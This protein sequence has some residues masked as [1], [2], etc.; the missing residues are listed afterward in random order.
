MCC[1][2]WFRFILLFSCWPLLLLFLLLFWPIIFLLLH[3]FYCTRSIFIT[4]INTDTNTHFLPFAVGRSADHFP[5]GRAVTMTQ[6]S[7][8]PSKYTH[9]TTTKERSNSW[10]VTQIIQQYNNL[11]TGPKSNRK[12]IEFCGLMH[13][14]RTDLKHCWIGGRLATVATFTKTL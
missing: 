14:F 1:Y 6:N 5:F 10:Q 9:T 12:N 2:G 11:M 8:Q 13:T 7:A 3:S 4:A